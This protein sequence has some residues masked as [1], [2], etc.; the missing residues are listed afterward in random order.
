MRAFTRHLA[1]ARSGP[2]PRSCLLSLSVG[3]IGSEIRLGPWKGAPKDLPDRARNGAA[4]LA[5]ELPPARAIELEVEAGTIEMPERA[6]RRDFVAAVSGLTLIGCNHRRAYLSAPPRWHGERDSGSLSGCLPL[7]LAPSAV[8]TLVLHLLEEP[9]GSDDCSGA[10]LTLRYTAASPHGARSYPLSGAGSAV[11]GEMH[12]MLA[13]LE[14]FSAGPVASRN[15]RPGNVAI[16][17]S[18][19]RRRAPVEALIVEGIGIAGAPGASEVSCRAAWSLRERS[20]RRL[21]GTEPL[22]FRFRPRHLLAGARPCG[23]PRPAYS[24]DPIEGAFWGWA[25]P[26]LLDQRLEAL[27]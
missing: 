8:Q 11:A 24:L 9:G 1:M 16:A 2:G 5:R 25:P 23:A 3:W 15:G 21:A 27:E 10:G 13:N 20:G 18:L 22:R 7:L 17:S 19:S 6:I 14:Q 26:L 4:I 12:A